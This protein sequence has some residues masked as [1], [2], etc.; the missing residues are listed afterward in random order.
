MR[1][2]F[3]GLKDI[4][5]HARTFLPGYI[6]FK[7]LASVPKPPEEQQMKVSQSAQINTAQRHTAL[8]PHQSPDRWPLLLLEI[9]TGT[10]TYFIK[11]N[12]W[13]LEGLM[14]PATCTFFIHVKG[15]AQTFIM[16]CNKWKIHDS[17]PPFMWS[18]QSFVKLMTILFKVTLKSYSRYKD[19]VQDYSSDLCKACEEGREQARS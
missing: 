10:I 12:S 19:T 13:G 11:K 1:W 3:G 4:S 9:D 2:A 16:K 14:A 18:P 7:V 15:N 6:N 5:W 17:S 8:T